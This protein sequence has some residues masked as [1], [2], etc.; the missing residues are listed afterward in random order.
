MRI[1]RGLTLLLGLLLLAAP[2]VQAG[3]W[4][5]KGGS[6]ERR[7]VQTEP[8]GLMAMTEA[9]RREFGPSAT[10]PVVIGQTIYHLAGENL[11]RMAV[12][13]TG[14]LVEGSVVPIPH[15]G[16]TEPVPVNRPEGSP[17]L[18]S[19]STPT[20]SPES[21]ILYFG[22]AYGRLWAYHTI[23]GW[24][25]RVDL[26]PGCPIVGS[27]LVLRVNN[28][29]H[30][31]VADR[32]FYPGEANLPAG[33][34]NCTTA[35]GKLWSVRGLDSITDLVDKQP[36][37]GPVEKSAVDGFGGFITP[38]A[39]PG[40][41]VNG[42]PT[43][44]IGTDGFS[45]G[46]AI[47]VTLNAA[48]DLTYKWKV[49]S[50]AGFAGNF[51]SDGTNGYWLDTAGTLW[52]AKLSNGWEPEGWGAQSINLAVAIGAGRLFTNTEP[53]V[54]TRANGTHLYITLRNW[55]PSGGTREQLRVEPT[56]SDGAVVAV[57]PDGQVKWFRRFPQT[58]G[59]DRL[60]INTAPLAIT[61]QEALLFGD[62]QGNLYAQA[63]DSTNRDGGHAQPY[64]HVAGEPLPTDSQRL[65]AGSEKPAHGSFTFS[66]VSGVG[67][68]PVM[69]GGLVLV[70]V[71][72]DL[73]G[74]TGGRL[75]A[76][77]VG[78]GYDLR[79]TEEPQPI[80]VTPGQTTAV[81]NAVELRLTQQSLGELCG[82]PLAVSWY[83][84]RADG[85]VIRPLGSTPLPTALAP[86]SAWPVT[87]DLAVEKGDPQN[88]QVVGIIDHAG[89]VAGTKAE[90][91]SAQVRLARQIAATL[92]MPSPKSCQ[93]LTAEVKRLP[94]SDEPEAGLANNLLV[95]P[96]EKRTVVDDPYIDRIDYDPIAMGPD[97]TVLLQ[98]GY[99]NN[100]GKTGET[101][102]AKVW[103]RQDPSQGYEHW[104]P[105]SVQLKCCTTQSVEFTGIPEGE[106]EL[107]GE[108][109]HEG[110]TNLANNRVVYPISVYHFKS[111]KPNG[112]GS[113]LTG[114]GD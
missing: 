58:D 76:Y 42:L 81:T 46:R 62:V 55:V 114:G 56:G 85:S 53:A 28:R 72:Y 82:G 91:A 11:W 84:T 49:D 21:G 92:A 74:V 38:S 10:Q 109:W 99:R 29:D 6:P 60:S 50:P 101:V 63:L 103:L 89:L 78:A 105:V 107:V 17:T 15:I 93:G 80:Q 104:T 47:L 66:Q 32:P 37:K 68:D 3:D 1:N 45:G 96:W 57:G 102:R 59:P 110:D 65:L 22:T 69:A 36:Y 90:S 83:L 73:G 88:G 23:D 16:K 5:T 61:S 40:P 112:P 25:R 54:E 111:S 97:F 34:P 86:G 106:Y 35:N 113:G 43:A 87:L 94:E 70:G 7:S 39:V 8:I 19:Q 31:I 30:V 27:P 64:F 77:H 71:N 18:I 4:P 14:E 51:T 2:H 48:N 13:P 79:W 98:L 9:W 100:L 33:R 44:L 24:F 26:Q 75:V 52:G 12:T 95:V 108:I 67:V 41:I 20:Y